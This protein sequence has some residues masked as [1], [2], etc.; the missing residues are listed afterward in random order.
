MCHIEQS[1][2]REDCTFLKEN[3]LTILGSFIPVR[4]RLD[5]LRSSKTKPCD[6][7]LI[8]DKHQRQRTVLTATLDSIKQQLPP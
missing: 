5:E 7:N 2:V 6:I 4:V 3:I 8:P 1:P